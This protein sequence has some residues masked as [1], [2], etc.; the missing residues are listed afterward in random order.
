MPAKILLVDDEVEI[1]SLLKKF[2]E[3]EGYEA[4]TANSGKEAIEKFKTEK[5]DI[6]LLD[7]RMPDM[8][9]IE[10]MKKIREIDSEVA[11]I[12]ATAVVDEKM[13]QEVVNMRAFD[14]IVKPF[15]LDYLKK[16][17]LVKI[18]TLTK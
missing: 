12:M 5:P 13:V 8:T 16:V 4:I 1:T 11:I 10:A 2:L 3:K 7:I 14:Y 15:D 9:G 6:I 17:L 18:A